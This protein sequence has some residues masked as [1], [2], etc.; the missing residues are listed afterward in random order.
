[1][2]SNWLKTLAFTSGLAVAT[3]SSMAGG[4]NQII[5]TY[6]G[7]SYTCTVNGNNEIVSCRSTY[8]PLEE[9]PDEGHLPTKGDCNARP[10]RCG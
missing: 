9:L 1:M 4:F 6:E 8:F 10:G 7:V 2:K 3:F 5:I